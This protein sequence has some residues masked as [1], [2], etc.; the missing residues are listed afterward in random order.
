MQSALIVFSGIDGAGKTTQIDAVEAELK[1]RGVAIR[2]IWARG[3]YTPLFSLAKRLAR[4]LHPRL[5]PPPGRSVQRQRVLR[6]GWVKTVWLHLAIWDLILFYG[7]W[8]RWLRLRGHAVL[9]DRYVADT[10]V[11]FSL[12]YPESRVGRWLSWRLLEAAAPRPTASFMLLVPV[13]ESVR[14]SLQ[15]NEPFPDSIETLKQRHH[16]YEA[17]CTAGGWQR[18]D[19][20]LDRVTL[21]RQLVSKLEELGRGKSTPAG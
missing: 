12:N 1:A 21:T 3:G 20:T 11:D 9:S 8:V 18:V 15:K 10:A 17:L 14:R 5:L 13:A 19:G 4:A 16:A 7:F 2:R 6:R